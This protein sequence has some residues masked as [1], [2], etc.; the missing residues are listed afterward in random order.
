MIEVDCWENAGETVEL[1]VLPDL[2]KEQQREL[3]E[4][5]LKIMELYS[6]DR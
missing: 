4:I 2:S 5:Y 6:S 1:G 3:F